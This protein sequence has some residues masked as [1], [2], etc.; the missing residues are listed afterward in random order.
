MKCY[1]FKHGWPEKRGF[2]SKL[3]ENMMLKRDVLFS[4][5]HRGRWGSGLKSSSVPPSGECYIVNK[6]RSQRLTSTGVA[7]SSTMVRSSSIHVQMFRNGQR[8][9]LTLSWCVRMQSCAW[10]DN[11]LFYTSI[12]M[13]IKAVYVQVHG[14]YCFVT[15]F[16]LF[17]W[18]WE[19]WSDGPI[20]LPGCCW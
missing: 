2:R 5:Q 13:A 20:L 14:I 7:L 9:I 1:S 12:Q 3:M 6:V 10:M 16:L 19:S 17:H 4:Q 18:F 15:S 11:T 8:S